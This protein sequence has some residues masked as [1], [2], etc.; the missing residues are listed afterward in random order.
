M[1]RT[2]LLRT[3]PALLLIAL[4][5]T[6]LGASP[7]PRGWTAGGVMAQGAQKVIDG[8]AEH[9]TIVVPKALAAAV[10][11]PTLVFYFSPTCGHCRTVA[12]EVDA[13]HDRLV[14][15]KTGRVL[16]VA[17][18]SS[19]EAD[20]AEFVATYAVGFE[21]LL[22]TDREMGA[23]LAVRS[24]PSALWVLPTRGRELEVTEL[25]YPYR[26]GLDA[27]VEARASGD[28][29]SVF[30]PGEYLGNN[31]CGSCHGLEQAAWALTHHSVAWRTLVE[32]GKTAD[33]ACTDCH[34]TGA[35]QPTGW[36][37]D[38]GDSILTDVGC[39]SCHSPGGPHDGTRVD[40]RTTC[41]TCHD[42]KHSIAF[43]VDKGLPLIDHYA[44]LGMTDDEAK[45][46]RMALYN[47]TAPRELLAFPDGANVGSAACV[48]CHASEH[49]WWSDNGHASAMASL[50]SEGGDD[51]ACVACHATAKRSGLPPQSVAGFR[52][53]EGVGCESCHGPGEAHV[54]AGG[55]TDNIEGLGEDCPVC[56]IE[57]VC[58]SCHTTKWSPDWSLETRLE[59]IRHGG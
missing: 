49:A 55:G 56:V 51:P 47:G 25:W 37:P 29:W 21:I 53:L 7:D 57:A 18:G 5:A 32:A 36:R 42:S 48:D 1:T 15:A 4:T 9:P 27:F 44:P 33:P 16:G 31:W 24:T 26:P 17:S 30:K 52:V 43:S 28:V 45:E 13:L 22:D 10:T 59:A 38:D 11:G 6:A 41:K 35:G 8:A 23:S 2:R 19:T 3:R 54:A 46:R 34:V 40:A 14:A 20:L 50:R 58:T 12:R 39:E